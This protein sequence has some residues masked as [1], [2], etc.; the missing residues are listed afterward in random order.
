[1]SYDSDNWN[2]FYE[3]LIQHKNKH[4][5]LEKI[6]AEDAALYRWTLSQ[7]KKRRDG[8]STLRDWMIEKLDDVGFE[9][10]TKLCVEEPL[11]KRLLHEAAKLK[12]KD[13]YQYNNTIR[14]NDSLDNSSSAN[15][16]N[17]SNNV[18]RKRASIKKLEDKAMAAVAAA[19]AASVDD[20]FNNPTRVKRK[21]S[22]IKKL[23]D[24]EM[25][26]AA[27]AVVAEDSCNNTP[28]VKKKRSSIKK[29]EDKELAM[30]AA[31]AAAADL[32]DP[33]ASIP[34][35]KPKMNTEVQLEPNLT[36]LQKSFST[37]TWVA[38]GIKYFISF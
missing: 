25:V 5:N 1:M 37:L 33:P 29:V 35:I 8:D 36:F 3:K 11:T 12:T 2:A 31:A 24:K 15:D 18:K 4:G 28:D 19:A 32:D 7:R 21:R 23:E 20:N 13:T 17:N 6:R 38:E 16:C 26:A 34:S 30:A 14:E 22:S 27:A 9:W 10:N